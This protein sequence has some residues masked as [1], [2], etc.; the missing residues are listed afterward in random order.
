MATAYCTV[1]DV[2][3]RLRMPLEHRDAAYVADC[4]EAACILIDNR[5]ADMPLPPVA[6]IDGYDVRDLYPPRILTPTPRAPVVDAATH[7]AAIGVAIRI[8]R[9]K[10]AEADVSDTWQATTDRAIRVPR[11]PLAGYTNLIDHHRHAWG[12]A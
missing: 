6:R 1:A 12:F 11:D 9:Y 5:L 3:E 4:T 2:L 8:Y 10:D 7:R